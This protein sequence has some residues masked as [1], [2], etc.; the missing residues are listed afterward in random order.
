MQFTTTIN[1]FTTL[2]SILIFSVVY[3]LFRLPVKIVDNV[4]TKTHF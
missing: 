1:I 3:L 2:I 4:T